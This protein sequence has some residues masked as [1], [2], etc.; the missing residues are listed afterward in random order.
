MRDQ[1]SPELP[2]A[3]E[4]APADP[5]RRRMLRL[6]AAGAAAVVTIRPALAATAGSVLNCQIP[7][8]DTANRSK[9][10][11]ADGSLVPAGTWGA[12]PPASRA[13]T[14]EE[15]RAAING[16]RSLPWTDSGRSS[17]Y[18]NYIRKLQRGT[19]GFTCYA[20]LQMPRR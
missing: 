15:V 10:I 9:W 13:F 6:G 20:S 7:V 3:A 19:S 17:A 5:T 2:P 8:P 14:G 12:Y 4:P 18:L 11:K 1:D 16:G